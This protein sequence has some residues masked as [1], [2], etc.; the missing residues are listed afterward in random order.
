MAELKD[1]KNMTV[2]A[3]RELARSVMG[4]G[5]SNLKTRADLIAALG[6]ALGRKSTTTGAGARGAAPG[7]GREAAAATPEAGAKAAGAARGAGDA[8]A[9]DEHAWEKGPGKPE[10]SYEPRPEGFFVSRIRG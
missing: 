4:P 8:A 1:L 7:T 9:G 2:R 3:L 5:H 10:Q 6:A